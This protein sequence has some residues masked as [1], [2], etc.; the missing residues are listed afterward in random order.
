MG[1]QLSWRPVPTLAWP[2]T[3]VLLAPLAVNKHPKIGDGC[4]GIDRFCE[5]S[6]VL[7]CWV[8]VTVIRLALFALVSRRVAAAG[9]SGWAA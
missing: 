4:L 5:W 6:D 1:Y 2:G 7:G 9:M 3:S 8:D